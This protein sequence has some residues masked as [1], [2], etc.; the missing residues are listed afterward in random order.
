VHGERT[1]ER[2]DG[3]EEPLLQGERDELSVIAK[4]EGDRIT[5]I[6][7]CRASWARASRPVAPA[8]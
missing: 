7:G 6:E 1:S 3:R 4:F 2:L 8:S 5:K